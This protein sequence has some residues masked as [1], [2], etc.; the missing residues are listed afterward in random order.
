MSTKGYHQIEYA[1]HKLSKEEIEDP[2]LVLHEFFQFVH[3]PEIRQELWQWLKLTVCEGFHEQSC[4]DK[5]N[6]IYVYERVDKLM[7]AIHIINQRKKSYN[8][9]QTGN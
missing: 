5:S 9:Y 8:D 2:F 3:L 6:L 7:E 1:T 4:I